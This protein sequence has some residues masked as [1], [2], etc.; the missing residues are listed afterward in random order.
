MSP[1]PHAYIGPADVGPRKGLL[2]CLHR[3]CDHTID[4]D[5]LKKAWAA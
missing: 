5:A 4:P 1:C 2:V 3:G